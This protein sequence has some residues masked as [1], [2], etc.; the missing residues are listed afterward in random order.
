MLKLPGRT[1]K[2]ANYQSNTESVWHL[3]KCSRTE[4]MH[5]YSPISPCLVIGLEWILRM[6]RRAC[7][8]GSSMS[9]EE[10]KE[11]GV[12]AW[13]HLELTEK[14]NRRSSYEFCGPVCQAAAGQGREC[15]VCWWPW[16]S[17]LC[18]MCRSRPSDSRAENTQTCHVFCAIKHLSTATATMLLVTTKVTL[19]TT[20]V[21]KGL[22]HMN[23]RHTD[24]M[25][26]WLNRPSTDV[27]TACCAVNVCYNNNRWVGWGAASGR[28][29]RVS[30]CAACE[31]PK[32]FLISQTQRIGMLLLLMLGSQTFSL[33]IL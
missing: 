32:A 6:S 33:T 1:P 19:K 20:N 9:E 21:W 7:S 3:D 8:L 2:W 30:W 24:V 5:V 12:L 15:Q 11:S 22:L 27:R 17:W 18:A 29:S 10:T 13:A 31:Q 26:Y 14:L 4:V 23:N 28:A 25:S 16:S